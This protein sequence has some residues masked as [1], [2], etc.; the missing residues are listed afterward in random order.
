MPVMRRSRLDLSVSERYGTL[1]RLV[2]RRSGSLA[3]VSR[4]GWRTWFTC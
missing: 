1:G 3:G 4:A 2:W